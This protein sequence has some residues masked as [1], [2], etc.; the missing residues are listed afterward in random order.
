MNNS[1]IIKYPK[2]ELTTYG[3]DNREI[4]FEVSKDW[5]LIVIAEYGFKDLD[6]FLTE[7]TWDLS[8]EIFIEAR[9]DNELLDVY[10]PGSIPSYIPLS[11]WEPCVIGV[12]LK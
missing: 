7:Y 9:E 2:I 12:K 5:L 8:H 11:S 6:E 3:I 1:K 10:T 4:T